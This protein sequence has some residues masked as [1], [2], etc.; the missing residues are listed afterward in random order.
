M[1]FVNPVSVKT[2]I[3]HRSSHSVGG[4]I[5]NLERSSPMRNEYTAPEVLEV[6]DA[7]E[8][9][10]GSKDFPGTDN[11]IQNLPADNELDD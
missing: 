7:G 10:L 6:G 3:N 8:M 9:I 2:R 11:D 5:H 1:R 4:L